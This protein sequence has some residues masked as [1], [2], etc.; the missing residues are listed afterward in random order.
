MIWG[1][2]R[3]KNSRDKKYNNSLLSWQWHRTGSSWSPVRTLLVEPLWCDLG[4]VPNSR[5]N[6]AAANLCPR[7]AVIKINSQLFLLWVP[8]LKIVCQGCIWLKLPGWLAPHSLVIACWAYLQQYIIVCN[9]LHVFWKI[10]WYWWSEF[11][12]SISLA[13]STLLVART[14]SE[15]MGTQKLHSNQDFANG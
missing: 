9:Y 14:A 12:L 1:R 2:E 3:C 4:F 13:I 7:L 6:K 5:G 10:K 15:A 11:V 8:G